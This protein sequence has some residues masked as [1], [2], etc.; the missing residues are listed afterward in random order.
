MILVGFLS[1]TRNALRA[2]ELATFVRSVAG[3]A[4]LVLGLNAGHLTRMTMTATLADRTRCAGM[5]LVTRGALLVLLA[6]LHALVAL[7][8]GNRRQLRTM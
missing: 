4:V 5:R 1:V 3:Q 7:A 8:T 2:R 6:R